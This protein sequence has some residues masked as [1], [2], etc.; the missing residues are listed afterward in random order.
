MSKIAKENVDVFSDSWT[1]LI[2]ELSVL[3]K[4]INDVCQGKTERQVYMSLPRPGVSH[5]ILV[6]I[7]VLRMYFHLLGVD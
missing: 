1:G 7:V 3:V 4:D 6:Y 2:N 5:C